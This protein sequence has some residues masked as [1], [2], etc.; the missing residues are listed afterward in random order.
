MNQVI[1]LPVWFIFLAAVGCYILGMIAEVAAQTKSLKQQHAERKKARGM[2]L[3]AIAGIVF[4]FY[5]VVRPIF[6]KRDK[7]VEPPADGTSSMIDQLM[8]EMK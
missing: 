7:E 4:F 1:E 5:M 6:R 2:A 3:V 8:D